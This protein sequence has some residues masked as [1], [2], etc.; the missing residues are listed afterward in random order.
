M[1]SDGLEATNNNVFTN[2]AVD[3]PMDQ[4]FIRRQIRLIDNRPLFVSYRK[5]G[6]L[7]PYLSVA[8]CCL[9]MYLLRATSL[10]E[11]FLTDIL[12]CF[13]YLSLW[14][15]HVSFTILISW[16]SDFCS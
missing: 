3:S 1:T 14:Q 7:S 10:F 8:L 16:A 15:R 6:G 4:I 2:L 11:R 9:R 13:H 12:R 5:T